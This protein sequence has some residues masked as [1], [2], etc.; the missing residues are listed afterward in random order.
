MK[1]LQALFRVPANL[2]SAGWRF[3][4]AV[5]G[6]PRDHLSADELIRVA[7]AA[8]TVGGG[9]YGALDALLGCLGVTFPAPADA[10][11]A[12]ALMTGILESSRRLRHGDPLPSSRLTRRPAR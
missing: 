11:L 1:R 7:L 12:V 5:P 9:A 4:N 3:V 8:L 6:S 10:A 2:V